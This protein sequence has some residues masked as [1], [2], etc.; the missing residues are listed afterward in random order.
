MFFDRDGVL[1]IDDGYTHKPSD[2]LWNLGAI[3]A[4]RAVNQAGWFAFVVTNQAGIGH[5]YHSEADVITFHAHMS[6]LLAAE[7]AHIDEYLHCPFHPEA[8]LEAYRRESEH[9]KPAPGMILELMSRW[10]VDKAKSFLVGDRESDLEAAARASIEA[11]HYRGGDLH[12]LVL[13]GLR[14]RGAAV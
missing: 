8:K 5:G 3:A 12:E 2:L 10:P 1:N 7:G 9:R 11:Y 6:Q 14:S 4:V 13:K